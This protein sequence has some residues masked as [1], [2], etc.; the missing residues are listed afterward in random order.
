MGS[1][2]V[3]HDEELHPNVQPFELEQPLA[4]LK[5][6]KQRVQRLQRPA[7]DAF[8][9]EDQVPTVSDMNRAPGVL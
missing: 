1:N 9:G 6:G 5:Q 4:G 3:L 2:F 8:A 7:T